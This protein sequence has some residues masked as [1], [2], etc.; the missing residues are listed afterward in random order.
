MDKWKFNN[1]NSIRH[2]FILADDPYYIT[3]ILAQSVYKFL[4]SPL[5]LVKD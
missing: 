4:I 2:T 5:G 3:K 1:M